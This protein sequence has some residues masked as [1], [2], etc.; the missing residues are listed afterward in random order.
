MN[1]ITVEKVP[2][3]VVKRYWTSIDYKIYNKYILKEKIKAIKNAFYD[4]KNDSY[5]PFEW[6]QAIKF[7]KVLDYEGSI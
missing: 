5:W 2:Q 4:S 3:N 7:L 6:E 1:T